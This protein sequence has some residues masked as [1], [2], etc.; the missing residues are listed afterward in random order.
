MTDRIKLS[1]SVGDFDEVFL[2][3]LLGVK[4]TKSADCRALGSEK[5][6]VRTAP[7]T[8]SLLAVANP[9]G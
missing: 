4:S 9:L 8:V 2:T 5:V 6:P 1:D 7:K 3:R